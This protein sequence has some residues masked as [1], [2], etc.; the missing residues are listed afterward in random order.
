VQ[1][2][3]PRMVCLAAVLAC[4]P[5]PPKPG[6]DAG[7]AP[8]CNLAFVGDPALDPE[9]TLL[10]MGHDNVVTELSDGAALP[11]IYPPQGGRVAFVGVRARNVDPCTV[12][13]TGAIRDP[14]SRQVRLDIRFVNLKQDGSGMAA[15]EASVASTWANIPLCPNG[16]ADQDLFGQPMELTVA[17]VQRDGHSFSRV[18][19]VVPF[20][21]EPDF[22][23][24][25]RCICDMDYEQGTT[26]EAPLNDGGMPADAGAP[27][28]GGG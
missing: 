6:P 1:I 16:W 27:V 9:F 13:L 3:V 5:E 4:T 26:C 24:D 21:A 22:Y 7:T 12:E 11:L 25:C 23:D 15:S 17:A 20:C 10:A 8:T 19:S 18:V 14:L 28:D 2:T